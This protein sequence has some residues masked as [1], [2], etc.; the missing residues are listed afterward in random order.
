PCFAFFV[1][2]WSQQER[3]FE[4]FF[5]EISIYYLLHVN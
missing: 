5:I 3:T 4:N 1:K 2:M